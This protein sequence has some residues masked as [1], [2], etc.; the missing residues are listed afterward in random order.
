MKKSFILIF[1]FVFIIS[2]TGCVMGPADNGD[3]GEAGNAADY[4]PIE[5]NTRYVFEGY[6]N[7]YAPYDVYID[8]TGAGK[9]QQ[10]IN[11]GGTELVAVFNVEENKVTKVLSRGESYFRQSFLDYKGADAEEVIIMGPVEIGT[12]WDSGAD[13][14][15]T[16]TNISVD[17]ETP[18]GK[19]KA[20]E[21]TTEGEDSK[22]INYYAKD[23]GLIKT[24]SMGSGYEVTSM[25][26]AI[27][28]DL[29]FVQNVRFYYPNIDDGIYYFKDI[30]IEFMTNDITRE[31]LCDI[32]KS[33]LE[34]GGLQIGKVLSENTLINSLY[35]N[36]DGMVYI[37]LNKAFLTEMNAGSGYEGM[38]L[39]SIANTFGGYF[40][41]DKL[42]LTIENELYES[43]H[44]VFQKGEFITVDVD[45]IKELP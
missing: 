36:D 21:I 6:G 11:N 32:Y 37:D 40:G 43:G 4:F 15:S 9:V 44:I 2:I 45:K 3:G 34:T 7:E 23:I 16:I 10:R 38:I 26:S 1:L 25:L 39:Q 35:L 14:V 5:E 18:S 29:P 27:E 28:K 42:I 31:V 13:F 12:S 33:P 17:I 8:Y 30:E 41:A 22:S 20:L 19:Y 24:V